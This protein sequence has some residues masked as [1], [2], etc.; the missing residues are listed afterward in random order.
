MY[1]PIRILYNRYLLINGRNIHNFWTFWKCG[2][3]E[4]M[5]PFYTEND[6]KEPHPYRRAL[7][8]KFSKPKTKILKQV[9]KDYGAPICQ[10]PVMLIRALII[11]Y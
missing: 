10:I 3:Q 2:L 5:A 11:S 8:P 4:K 7:K 6:S 1:H 9:R